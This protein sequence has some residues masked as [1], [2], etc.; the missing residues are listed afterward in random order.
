[1]GKKSVKL[2][3]GLLVGV[4]LWL[5]AWNVDAANA[6]QSATI[7]GNSVRIWELNDHS[8]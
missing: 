4:L 7:K 8:F 5:S 6:G 1:M 2:L 3:C